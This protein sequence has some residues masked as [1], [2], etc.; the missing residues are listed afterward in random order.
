MN[1]QNSQLHQNYQ[2]QSIYFFVVNVF[3][4][5][6]IAF[7]YNYLGISIKKIFLFG[8]NYTIKNESFKRIF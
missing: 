4:F 3:L 1:E 5:L 2:K 7:V 6:T 8:K